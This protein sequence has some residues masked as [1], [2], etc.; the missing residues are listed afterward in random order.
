M[1]VSR[2]DVRSTI[3]GCVVTLDHLGGGF[4]DEV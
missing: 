2:H 3:V 1:V 4:A